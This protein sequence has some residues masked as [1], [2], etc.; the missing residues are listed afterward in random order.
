MSHINTHA[1]THARTHT[2]RLCPEES[3][4][5]EACGLKVKGFCNPMSFKVGTKFFRYYIFSKNLDTM[6]EFVRM[7]YNSL[8]K[9]SNQYP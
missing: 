8:E 4:G 1:R 6:Q 2:N 7:V 9:H 3:V 5:R